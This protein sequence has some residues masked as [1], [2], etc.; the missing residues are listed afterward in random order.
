VS[1]VVVRTGFGLTTSNAFGSEAGVFLREADTQWHGAL[2]SSNTGF[3]FAASNLP[4][5]PNRGSVQQPERFE[6]LTRD[7]AETGGP[8]TRWADMFTSATGQWASQTMP[9]MPTGSTQGSRLLYGNA[10]FRVRASAYDQF[11]MIYSG[12]R[13]DLSNGGIPAGIEAFAGRRMSPKF[14][15]PYGFPNE[16]E[17]DHLDLIQAGWTHTWPGERW[18]GVLD[19]RYGFSTAHLDTGPWLR[20]VPDQSRIDLLDG[21][22]AGSPPIGNLAVR[23]RNQIAGAWQPEPFGGDELRHQVTVGTAWSLASPRNRFTAPSNLN[24]ITAGGAPAFVVVFN[25]LGNTRE[26]VRNFTA[27]AAD[28]ITVPKGF[29]LDGAAIVDASHG[30]GIT[31]NTVSPR[32]AFGWQ[33]PRVRGLVLR[34]SYMRL[35]APLGGRYLDFGNPNSLGGSEYQWIDRNHDG[36]F[37]PGEQ[38][39]LLM[40]FGG[41]YSSISPSL[42]RPYADEFDVHAEFAVTRKFSANIQLFRRDE[43]DRVAAMDTGVPPSAFT[44]VSMLD[45]GPDG[46]FGTFDDRPFTVYQQNPATS[47]RDRY[48]LTNPPG[49]RELWGDCHQV[50]PD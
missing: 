38:G 4:S 28:H 3:P 45:P 32:I 35:N 49:L 24:L 12:S 8:L 33:I 31:W 30:T 17:T 15:L 22:I 11:E 18:L 40:R 1:E 34:G 21:T 9:L 16:S 20:G 39:A 43:K 23:P 46:L 26:N 7:S 41:L 10:R 47:G 13:V 19:L 14:F 27:S 29:S 44:P 42:H 6:W 50:V 25:T 5:E 37:E 48:L 2:S 36:W